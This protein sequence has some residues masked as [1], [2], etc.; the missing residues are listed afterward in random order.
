MVLEGVF[1]K[2]RFLDLIRYFIVFEDMGGGVLTK[3]MA[4]YHQFHAVNFAVEQTL[5][6]AGRQ[7]GAHGRAGRSIR[8]RPAAR[9]RA[10]RPARRRRLA[11]PGF[12]QEL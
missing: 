6:A 11:H 2:R 1:D 5:R 10:R 8:V 9:R 12:G 3:K 4:G 7:R